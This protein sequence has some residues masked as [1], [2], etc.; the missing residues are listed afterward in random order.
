MVILSRLIQD[1]KPSP[2]SGK[3]AGKR[4]TM[5]WADYH[6]IDVLNEFI[7]SLAETND[8]ASIIPIGKSYEGREMKVLAITKVGIIILITDHPPPTTRLDQEPPISGWRLV[9]MPGS[10]YLLLWLHTLSG[11]W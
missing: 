9:Y 2:K 11:S 5:D 8:F 6:D 4:Y 3:S 1:T 7:E 10:G